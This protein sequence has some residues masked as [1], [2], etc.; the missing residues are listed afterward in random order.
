MALQSHSQSI[1]IEDRVETFVTE[2]G[3]TLVIMGYEDARVLLE[4]VLHY[5][6][7]DSL[8]T[9][10]KERDSLNLRTV[11]LQKEVLMTMGQEKENLQSII[12]N[13]NQML[14]NKDEAIALKDDTIKQQKKEIRKQKF[15]K[16]LG[17]TG[18][19]I[20]PILILIILG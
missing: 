3:D 18:S 5:E 12:S 13:L 1:S 6:Y 7:T 17:F 9:V 11:S 20:L 16:I 19:I 14:I 8:L 2:Q 10:Y 15:L 4:D